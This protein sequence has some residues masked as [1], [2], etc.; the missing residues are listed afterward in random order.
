IAGGGGPPPPD[1]LRAGAAGSRLP[2]GGGWRAA[3]CGVFATTQSARRSR[4]YPRRCKS[5]G[6]AGLPLRTPSVRAQQVAAFPSVV[7]GGQRLVAV[8]PQLNR[9]GGAGPTRGDVDRRGRRASPSGPPPC[10]RSR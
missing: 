3:F 6:E 5:Q 4:A 10:G 9:P 2:V 7:G 8:L 1:P